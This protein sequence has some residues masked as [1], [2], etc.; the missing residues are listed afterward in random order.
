MYI[1]CDWSWDLFVI[2]SS[3][4]YARFKHVRYIANVFWNASHNFFCKCSIRF[5]VVLNSCLD[6]IGIVLGSL[7]DSLGFVLGSFCRRFGIVV[8][9]FWRHHPLGPKLGSKLR[10]AN[11]E[12]TSSGRTPTSIALPWIFDHLH[13]A[14]R[15][16][17]N[18][19]N[20]KEICFENRSM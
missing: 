5:G 19:R 6:R 18:G 4:T 12:H 17:A 1:V 2:K 15:I 9:S 14:T 16:G 3:W 20:C 13:S 7:W 10:A 11:G 8:A